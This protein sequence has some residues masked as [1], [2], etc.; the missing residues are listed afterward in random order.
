M[1]LYRSMTRNLYRL[2]L[3]VDVWLLKMLKVFENI[4]GFQGSATIAALCTNWQNF[5]NST[6]QD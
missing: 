5:A 4:I 6:M 1:I 3:V 2:V